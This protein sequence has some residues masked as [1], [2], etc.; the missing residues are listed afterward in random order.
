VNEFG[1]RALT[2]TEVAL[3]LHILDGASFEGAEALGA[4]VPLARVT[5]GITT[6]L[7]LAVAGEA[8]ASAFRHGPIPGRAFIEDADGEYEGEVLVWVA[9]GYLSG[10]EF[11]SV[12]D[13]RPTGMPEADRV[14][15]VPE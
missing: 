3:L 10:L 7:D 11:A 4:Q 13:E 5:A 1:E 9:D 6:F 15:V 8:P 2:P 14:R 12:M